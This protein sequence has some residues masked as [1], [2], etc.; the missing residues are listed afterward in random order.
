MN[1]LRAYTNNTNMSLL[2][3]LSNVIL[4]GV[5]PSLHYPRF[6]MLN[7]PLYS[8]D[9]PPSLVRSPQSSGVWSMHVDNGDC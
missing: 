9:H 3:H 5:S 8:C 2:I 1:V 4:S 6:S 7:L